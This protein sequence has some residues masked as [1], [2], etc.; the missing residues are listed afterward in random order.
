[1]GEAKRRKLRDPNY[2]KVEMIGGKSYLE[3]KKRL[4]FTD[5]QWKEIK[6]HFRVVDASDDVDEAIDG[7]WIYSDK[8]KKN[9]AFTGRFVSCVSS[10]VD[11]FIEP[12]YR[13]VENSDFVDDSVDAVWKY[14]DK[15]G[16]VKVSCTG[17]AADK[18]FNEIDL[19]YDN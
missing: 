14:K 12:C 1:M 3:W 4:Y 2:G 16:N 8:G 6:P 5:K 17:K 15:K 9:I 19:F 7:V 18:V 13:E 10:D 11:T